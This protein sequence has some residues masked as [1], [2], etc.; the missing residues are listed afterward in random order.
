MGTVNFISAPTK[1]DGTGG[2]GSERRRISSASWSRSLLPELS[3]I[4]VASRR[5][6]RSTRKRILTMPCSPRERASGGYRLL[7]SKIATISFFQI[8]A[9]QAAMSIST[10][11]SAAQAM[12]F[13]L[14][15]PQLFV[16]R[17]DGT[18]LPPGCFVSD[19]LLP[20]SFGHSNDHPG[21]VRRQ[22]RKEP[23]V[24]P[25]VFHKLFHG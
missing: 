21:A 23:S 5:P 7:R 15:M 19:L 6:R 11:P 2:K 22:D 17:I 8:A 12:L 16:A 1:S 4:S 14:N 3:T 18:T 24:A 10:L 13:Q 9:V 25:R 20:Q